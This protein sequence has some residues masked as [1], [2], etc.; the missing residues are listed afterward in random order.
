MERKAFRYAER[1]IVAIHK[2]RQEHPETLG[3]AVQRVKIRTTSAFPPLPP[4]SIL[5]VIEKSAVQSRAF[6]VVRQVN[7][8]YFPDPSGIAIFGTIQLQHAGDHRVIAFLVCDRRHT[9]KTE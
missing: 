6:T 7:R 2:C 9:F 1:S 8:P 5:P 4:P 3:R